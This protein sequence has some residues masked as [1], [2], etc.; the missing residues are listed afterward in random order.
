MGVIGARRSRPP[1]GSLRN[2][3]SP[4]QGEVKR[5]LTRL[6]KIRS[7]AIEERIGGAEAVDPTATA[8]FRIPQREGRTLAALEAGCFLEKKK[9]EGNLVT[10]TAS[11]PSSLLQRYRRYIVQDHGELPESSPAEAR[12][13]VRA[14]K[15]SEG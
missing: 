15:N 5:E 12:P 8:T 3:T 1:P 6:A 4:F 14:R 13:R 10:F 7:A 2:P 11:G 9:Y